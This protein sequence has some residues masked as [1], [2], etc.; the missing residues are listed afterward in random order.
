MLLGSLKALVKFGRHVL[1][2]RGLY[3]PVP[4]LPSHPR[5][6]RRLVHGQRDYQ[7]QQQE[8]IAG[9]WC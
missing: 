8:N 6:N 9:L 7:F 1:Q 3:C 5:K 4:V 2:N